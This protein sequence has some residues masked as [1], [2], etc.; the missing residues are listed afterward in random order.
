[1]SNKKKVEHP[2]EEQWEKFMPGIAVDCTIFGY[3]EKDLKVLI[4]E[5]KKT[6]FFALP[7]GFVGKEEDL[8]EA[9]E[10]ILL[11]RTGLKNIYL[12]Q[13]HTF[14]SLSRYDPTPMREIMEKNGF[15]PPDDHWLLRRFI[16]IGYYALVDFK[17]AD[18]I[19][20]FLSDS[21]KWY[22]I[23]SV[24]VLIQ[25]HHKI[26][27]EALNQLR[28]NIDHKAIGLTL[29]D[30][31][32]TMKELQNLYETILDKK[33]NRS[34]FHRKMMNSERLERIGKKN[35]GKSH[36]SPYLYRFI[37]EKE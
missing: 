26:I 24:P 36:R 10:R 12:N 19:P 14:G 11:E 3:H 37:R 15:I 23:G 25:D 35:T 27:K 33:L 6:G 5:Y 13:F 30:D 17:E 16:S 20:D 9:A 21:C 32:F 34:S 2:D 22:D 4:L 18:P 28:E 31:I 8:D 1:M 29:L 7:G